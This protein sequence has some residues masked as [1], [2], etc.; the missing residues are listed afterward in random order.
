M[1]TSR[2]RSRNNWKRPGQSW[3]WPPRGTCSSAPATNCFSNRRP[4]SWSASSP[5]SAAWPTSRATSP[6]VPFGTPRGGA[7]SRAD[8]QLLDIL[9]HPVY[10]LLRVLQRTRPGAIDAVAL[11]VSPRGTVHALVRCGEYHGHPGRHPGRKTVESSCAWSGRTDRSW[12]TMCVA[13]CSAP[14]AREA[15]ASTSCWRRIARAGRCWWAARIAFGR[16][17]LEQ[18]RQLSRARRA[19]PRILRLDPRRARRRPCSPEQP[20]GNGS[21]L[22]PGGGGAARAKKRKALAASAPRPLDRNRACW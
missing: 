16:R 3:S 9:P 13:P 14:S 12:R 19:V 22:R 8:H 5:R 20:A 4:G 17:F 11:E 21:D 15:R 10:L 6:F 2:S 18:R 1:C 7:E